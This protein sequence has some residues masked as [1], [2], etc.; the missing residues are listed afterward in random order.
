MTLGLPE[1]MRQMLLQFYLQYRNDIRTIMSEMTMDIP[2]YHNLEWRFDV[3]V[4]F[5]L[6]YI[7]MRQKQIRGRSEV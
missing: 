6:L 5:Q 3:K 7:N 2:H 1:S 4:S